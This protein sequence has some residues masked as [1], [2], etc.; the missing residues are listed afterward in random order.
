MYETDEGDKDIDFE[1]ILIGAVDDLLDKRGSAATPAGE[2][3]S[4][5]S[6]SS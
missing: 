4:G 2:A 5:V 3:S 1:K 6:D